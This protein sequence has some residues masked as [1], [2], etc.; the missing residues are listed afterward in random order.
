DLDGDGDLD[1]VAAQQRAGGALAWF[2]ND[3]AGIFTEHAIA[4]Q[5]EFVESLQLGDLDGDGDL[6]LLVADTG[7][8]RIVVLTNEGNGEFAAAQTAHTVRFP[9]GIDVGDLDRDGDL[10][11]VFAA[12]QSSAAAPLE[13]RLVGW[14]E[15]LGG[16]QFAAHTLE[17]GRSEGRTV[18][19]VDLDRDGLQD[20]AAAF[21][22]G[23]VWY[24]RQSDGQFAAHTLFDN[25][26]GNLSA[27]LVADL[28]GDADS[29]FFATGYSM[30]GPL[31]GRYDGEAV[32][33]WDLLPPAGGATGMTS[34]GDFDGD[35][36]LD[37]AVQT[38][39]M[40]PIV[41]YEATTLVDIEGGAEGDEIAVEEEAAAVVDVTFVRRG[42]VQA[43]LVVGFRIGGAAKYVDDYLL[44][45]ATAFDGT[46][47]TITIPSGARSAALHVTIVDDADV[48]LDEQLVVELQQRDDYV[49]GATPEFAITI[50]S[51]ASAGERG[52]D[53]GDA[54]APYPTT[55]EQQGAGHQTIG[56]RLG[57]TRSRESNG[58]PSAAADAD[59]D[60]GAAF[61]AVGVGL[62]AATW[63]I[64]LQNA[65]QGAWVDAW[66]DFNRDGTWGGS[67]ERIAATYLPNVGVHVL[68]F[69]VPP[70]AL[71]GTTFARV[72]VSSAGGLGP[73]GIAGDGEVEDYA[74][75]IHPPDAGDALLIP[76]TSTVWQDVDRYGSLKA[77]G[78]LDG[79]GDVDFLQTP[80][81]AGALQWIENLGDGVF[82]GRD[83]TIGLATASAAAKAVDYDGDGDL[84]VLASQQ[85]LSRIVWYENDGT[86]QFAERTLIETNGPDEFA[87]GDLDGDGDLDV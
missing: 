84:D 47:G 16:L 87:V 24:Q 6:D 67:D 80:L 40:D 57:A 46:L 12:P 72:R 38:S 35:G 45:G 9:V 33:T 42:D 74:V 23:I 60:D 4:G 82:A 70:T 3:G 15:N 29:D 53:L 26:R 51:V 85:A 19:I 18:R 77:V 66:I 43:E 68:S 1:L 34:V 55:L 5:F 36:D 8:D 81:Q 21:A 65:P 37:V 50:E 25:P 76:V 14:V 63:S 75:A 79:D 59:L 49:V 71:S 31:W 11:F 7:A 28:D 54:P 69:D 10:D 17:A 39:G 83:L 78:D 64:D 61:G 13:T 52:G 20:V 48:E 30:S 41:W 27:M 86:G 2:E 73:G 62:L 44:D 32:P 22:G 56:P 58:V